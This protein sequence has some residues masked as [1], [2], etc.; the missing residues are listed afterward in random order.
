[1]RRYLLKV[2]GGFTL[3]AAMAYLIGTFS[4][5]PEMK[6]L[7]LFTLT[8]VWRIFF[9]LMISVAWGVSF[10]ILAATNKTFGRI[11]TPIVDILQSIPI[12]G[13]FPL[14]IGFL[15]AWGAWGI[16][17]SVILL[18]FTSMAW[19]IYFGVLGAIS[20]I[21]ANVVESSKS[22]G[23]QGWKYTRH[24]V[25]PAI[26]PAV[27]SGA[28]LAWSDGW[29]FMI[30]AEYVQY[31][32]KVV[33]PPSGGVGYL[34]AQAAYFYKDMNL[35]IILLVFITTLIIVIN[36]LTWHKLMDKAN[37]GTFKPIISIDLS[38]VGKIIAAEESSILALGIHMPKGFSAV[39]QRLRQYSRLERI[40][41]WCVLGGL[42][43][44]FVVIEYDHFPALSIVQQGLSSPPADQL[45][46]LSMFILLTMG[47]LTIAYLVSLVVAIGLGVLAAESKRAASLIYPIYDIG[48]GVPILAL[49]PVIYLGLSGVVGSQRLA[50]EITCI[51]M[52]VLDMIW[53]MFINITSAIKNIPT[54][55]KEV[56]SLFGFKGLHRITHLIIP[57][58]LPAI[59]TGSI[60]S[61]GTGWNT[62]IFSEY[63][64]SSEPG[65]PSVWVPGIGSLLDLSK[66]LWKYHCASVPSRHHMCNSFVDGRPDLEASHQAIREIQ[67]GGR[68]RC[69]CL[70]YNTSE[71]S[72][73]RT[74]MRPSPSTT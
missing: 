25:L 39:S 37:T 65:V 63:L 16:E 61:W 66:L 8:T 35:A 18:L 32:Q 40:I 10:G 59:V 48:Q 58:I 42:L 27:V 31:Q 19:A 34:L 26:A 28:N 33:S 72:S 53:Y 60:L 9:T 54:E 2:V 70:M 22:F 57:S 69:Q 43:L 11:L 64:Q 6:N 68:I 30:A 17:T 51:V 15:Y 21:P 62:I 29:F 52:L 55:I 5:Y 7:P 46:N 71:K 74:R 1:M 67:G 45:G 20:S 41:L 23:I 38:G 12:L 14:A 73:K 44:Y 50:L 24:I 47:R 49:F 3:L 4:P 56:G 36:S 13:Y